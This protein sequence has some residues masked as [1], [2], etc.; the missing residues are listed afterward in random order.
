MSSPECDHYVFFLTTFHLQS[1]IIMSSSSRHVISRCR[2]EEE[3]RLSS[4]TAFHLQHNVSSNSPPS[5]H[6]I[7]RIYLNVQRRNVRSGR[8]VGLGRRPEAVTFAS[9]QPG[10][11]CRGLIKQQ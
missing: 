7:S 9:L 5:R 2:E 3:I 1:V 10:A 6:F 4:L 11:C 8:S